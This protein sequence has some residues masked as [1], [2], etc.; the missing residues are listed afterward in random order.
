MVYMSVDS[1]PST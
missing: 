1:Q